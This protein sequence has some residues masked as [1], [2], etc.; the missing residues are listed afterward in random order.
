MAVF[1]LGEIAYS[2]HDSWLAILKSRWTLVGLVAVGAVSLALLRGAN[3]LYDPLWAS[4]TIAGLI[5]A[6]WAMSRLVRFTNTPVMNSLEFMGK[7]SV[8][9]YVTHFPIIWTVMVTLGGLGISNP[10]LLF[11]AAAFSA[12]IIGTALAHLRNRVFVVGL[13][14]ALPARTKKVTKARHASAVTVQ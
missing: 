13:L 10:W 2:A 12:F 5:L 1:F 6:C 11:C 3:V 8:V 9:F 4:A 14:F 7:N